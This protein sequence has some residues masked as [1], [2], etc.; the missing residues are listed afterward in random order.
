MSQ[1]RFSFEEH[2]EFHVA[3]VMDGNGRWALRQGKSRIYGH[4]AGGPVVRH[5]VEAAP[6]LGISTLTLYAFS[7]DNW[8]RPKQEVNLLMQLFMKY[9]KSEVKDCIK[10]GVRL[11]FI[12]RRDRIDPALAMAME[13]AESS[14]KDGSTIH[15]RV[16]IDYSSR[17]MI[18]KAVSLLNGQKE[19]SREDFSQLLAEAQNGGY[20]SPDVDLLIRT[21]GEKRLSDFLLWECAYAELYFTDIM[22]PDFNAQH[23]QAAVAEFHERDRRF[24]C[25]PHAVA[26]LEK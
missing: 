24:G 4:R 6:D 12:G 20:T 10:N 7:S 8:Q 1:S 21:G 13:T 16:A 11:S 25:V 15:L 17:D 19:I 9:L 5:I 18:L 14:T 2:P 26:L 23:L 3:I 22:W